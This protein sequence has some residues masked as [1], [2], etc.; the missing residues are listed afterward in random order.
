MTSAL[1]NEL[2]NDPQALGYAAHLPDDP[3]RV[4]DLLNSTSTTMV[5]AIHSTTAQAWAAQGPYATIVDTGNDKTH[6][7]RASCLLLQATISSGV[8]IHLERSDVQGMFGLW[9]ST[10]VITQAQHD[11]LYVRAT[12]PASRAE[13]LGIPAPT[14]RDILNAWSE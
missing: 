5:K 3:V 4:V 12:Q 1:A 9:L 8:D 2:K 14:A 11:D 7:C 13:V 6:V 10:G